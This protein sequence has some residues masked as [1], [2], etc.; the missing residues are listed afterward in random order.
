MRA[1]LALAVLGAPL[2][3]AL[4]NGFRTPA[5]G[6]SSW[7]GFTQNIEEVMLRGQA[8]GLVSSGLFEAGYNQIWIDASTLCRRAPND[9]PR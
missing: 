6:W 1:Q 4:D 9:L 8:D 3:A 5:M 2:V 7:Y